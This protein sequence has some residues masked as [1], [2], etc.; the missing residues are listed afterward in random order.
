[1]TPALVT[2][3]AELPVTIGEAKAQLR[4]D[5]FDDD[6]LISGLIASAVDHLDGYR[7][8]LGRAII[9]QTWRVGA[10]RWHPV[11]PLPFPDVQ[12]A[13]ITY[14]DHEGAE[15]TVP[16]AEYEV[17]AGPLGSRIYF[18][19]AFLSPQLHD[20]EAE[21]ITITFTAGYGGAA[22]A[23]QDIKTAITLMVQMDYDQPEP[24]KS[25]A[26]HQA[27][28]AKIDKHRWTRV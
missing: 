28:R 11:M 15:Q 27:I 3:P 4:V 10:R 23:P 25:E 9:T 1:M 16:T 6:A 17:I 19:D 20:D 5:H 13:I 22:D 2:A 8:V 14:R 24:Q 21:P 12:S 7:G 26:I 18:K